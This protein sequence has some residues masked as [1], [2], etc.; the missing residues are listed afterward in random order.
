MR[1]RGVYIIAAS[2]LLAGMALAAKTPSY[3]VAFKPSGDPALDTL[4][5]Q[6][7]SLVSLQTKLPAG[8]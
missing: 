1:A 5:K 2:M 7:S 8:N 6:T 4:L 3:Q